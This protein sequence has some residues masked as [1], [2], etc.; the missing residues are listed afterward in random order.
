MATLQKLTRV[1]DAT[2][3]DWA[4]TSKG[5]RVVD[6]SR[7]SQ[8]LFHVALHYNSSPA[9]PGWGSKLHLIDKIT[10]DIDVII[11]TEIERCLRVLIDENVITDLV[12]TVT[13]P[14]VGLRGVDQ[15]IDIDIA[16]KDVASGQ[17]DKA[18][19]GLDVGN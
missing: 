19:F 12:V 6:V 5:Q 13:V 10:D 17:P 7:V 18:S 9:F 3:R 14:E 15:V 11:T 1:I 2:T 4:F 8:V 16:F